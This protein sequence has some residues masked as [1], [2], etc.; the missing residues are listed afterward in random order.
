MAKRASKPDPS[1]RRVV[2]YELTTDEKRRLGEQAAKAGQTPSVW[3]GRQ[4][5]A[6]LVAAEATDA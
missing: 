5:R 6:A 1:E 4:L 3:A 2:T